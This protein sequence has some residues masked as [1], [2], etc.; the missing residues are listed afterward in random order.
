M[1]AETGLNYLGLFAAVALF[2]MGWALTR[3]SL[4]R[5]D[6]HLKRHLP[7]VSK[8]PH[9]ILVPVAGTFSSEREFELLGLLR[10]ERDMEIRLLHVIEVPMTLPLEASL[11]GQ[12][13]EAEEIIRHAERLTALQGLEIFSEI[14]KGR[15]ASEEIIRCA[16][17]W[18]ANII[19]MSVRPRTGLLSILFGHTSERVRHEAPGEVL[20]GEYP[21][22]ILEAAA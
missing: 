15:V 10:R 1:G 9:K 19:L 4:W 13:K 2:V 16:K 5:T 11:A 14:K 18:G 6:R 17:D 3:D 12:E 21:G 22:Q 7:H 8:T 20:L